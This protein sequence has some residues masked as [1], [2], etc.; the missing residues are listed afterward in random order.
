MKVYKV[1]FSPTGGTKK[2]IDIIS[3]VWDCEEMQIDLSDYQKDF[4]KI[5]FE[6]DDICIVATPSFGGRVPEIVV[7]RLKEMKGN[8]VP[9]IMVSVYGNRS[10]EDTLIELKDTL[11]KSNFHCVA[12]I[13]AIAEHSIMRQFGTNR[14]DESDKLEIIN[15]AKKV[16]ETINQNDGLKEVEV[17]GKSS[18][19][20][21]KGLPIKPKANKSCNRCGVCARKCPMQ[22][23]SVD[24]ITSVN[25]EKCISCMQCISICPQKA[26]SINKLLVFIAT[27]KMK[28]SC[29]IRK[30]NELFI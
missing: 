12:A 17:P 19:R 4:S 6:K 13:S 10:Y 23:I 29:I 21:Y 18:Y 5:T 11:K 2:I 30:K 7:S 25:K 14:P 27:Q 1:Y 20:E 3:K 22:A 15:Y 28:K 9:T 16:K 8:Q 24:D 26:R